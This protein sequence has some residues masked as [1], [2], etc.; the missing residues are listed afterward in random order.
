MRFPTRQ[1]PV[2]QKQDLQKQ[3]KQNY[4]VYRLTVRRGLMVGDIMQILLGNVSADPRTLDK[5]AE[6]GDGTPY[7][8]QT[9]ENCNIKKPIFTLSIS[10][11][12]TSYNYMYIPTWNAYYFLSEPDVID[13]VRCRYFAE[14][15]V[16]TTFADT[17]KTLPAFLTRTADAEKQ[18]K[19][20][21]DTKRPVQSNRQ[22]ETYKFNRTPFTASYANDIV[23][24]LTV[25]GGNHS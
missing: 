4:P 24:L 3:N 18:N 13:G 6:F 10:I 9:F 8:I 25:I 7:N 2:L 15:D 23:Y 14:M 11:G 12:L 22:L 1:I 5:R 20:I 16:L 17:I 19:Y 21:R